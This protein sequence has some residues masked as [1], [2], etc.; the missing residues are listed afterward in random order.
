MRVRLM[1]QGTA[2][3]ENGRAVRIGRACAERACE[4]QASKKFFFEKKNQKTFVPCSASV[5]QCFYH[6][7]AT[8]TMT[9]TVQ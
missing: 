1:A 5:R 8:P 7:S 2:L 4:K 9:E 6:P 3:I